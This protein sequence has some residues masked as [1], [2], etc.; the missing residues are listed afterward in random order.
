MIQFLATSWRN[1]LYFCSLVPL[2]S[3]LYIKN[4]LNKAQFSRN[5]TT[6]FDHFTVFL[7]IE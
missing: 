5:S 2:F 7:T 4:E 6:F 1:F 3:V